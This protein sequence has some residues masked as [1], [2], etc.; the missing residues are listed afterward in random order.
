ME[1]EEK[2]EEEKAIVRS[3]PDGSDKHKYKYKTLS[4]KVLIL[5]TEAVSTASDRCLMMDGRK[6]A[7]FSLC[8]AHY[9][10][11]LTDFCMHLPAQIHK[12][13]CPASFCDAQF[14]HKSICRV[15]SNAQ[16]IHKSTGLHTIHV[17][18]MCKLC[19]GHYTLCTIKAAANNKWAN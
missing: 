2:E 19:S 7:S 13:A 18:Q 15:L 9:I 8:D 16:N 6:W 10:H 14:V 12:W 5:P 4:L 17:A 11:K 1:E 3:A